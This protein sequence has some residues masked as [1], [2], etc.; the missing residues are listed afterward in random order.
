MGD[1]WS[2]GQV[3]IDPAQNVLTITSACLAVASSGRKPTE[4]V[5][6]KVGEAPQFLIIHVFNGEG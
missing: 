1:I 4:F 5:V 3:P 2:E 6:R